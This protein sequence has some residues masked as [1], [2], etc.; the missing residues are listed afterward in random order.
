M[1]GSRA[2]LYNVNLLQKI[3]NKIYDLVIICLK[4]DKFNNHSTKK[5]ILSV[6]KNAVVYDYKKLLN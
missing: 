4:H 2:K 5:K 3:P 6:S 1:I